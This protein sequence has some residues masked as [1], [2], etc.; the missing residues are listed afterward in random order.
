MD[1]EQE[2][3]NETRDTCASKLLF[4]GKNGKSINNWKL[5][6][7]VKYNKLNKYN[8]AC[9]LRFDSAIPYGEKVTQYRSFEYTSMLS[10]SG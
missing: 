7:K 3:V 1:N 9:W 5:F 2:H 6:D 10:E 8:I 4:C